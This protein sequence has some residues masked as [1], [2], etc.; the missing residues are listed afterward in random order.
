ML[1]GTGYIESWQ[2][3]QNI[4]SVKNESWP[5]HTGPGGP[6]PR[7][8]NEV[9]T[10]RAREAVRAEDLLYV[11]EPGR[12]WKGIDTQSYKRRALNNILI[13]SHAQFSKNRAMEMNARGKIHS[14]LVP[15]RAGVEP[16]RDAWILELSPDPDTQT[17]PAKRRAW[18]D[19]VSKWAVSGET[20]QGVLYERWA[21]LSGAYS[22]ADQARFCIHAEIGRVGW[23][24]DP[25]TGDPVAT[26]PIY[27]QK[28]GQIYDELG[29]L[30]KMLTA[31]GFPT[32]KRIRNIVTVQ[33]DEIAAPS[34]IPA[35][36]E[37]EAERIV[38]LPAARTAEVAE[39]TTAGGDAEIEKLSAIPEETARSI[40]IQ[41][42]DG[43]IETELA[44]LLIRTK[45][46]R[47]RMNARIVYLENAVA[48]VRVNNALR[49]VLDTVEADLCDANQEGDR[50]NN[51]LKLLREGLDTVRQGIA[52]FAT[53]FEM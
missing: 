45:A 32:L 9:L 48:T 8:L 22:S 44:D 13:E 11:H 20:A 17:S 43:T 1:N 4:G 52:E 16:S 38:R 21:Q 3:F 46:E 29:R 53:E 19:I 10:W 39:R 5:P 40:G 42:D 6:E 27:P 33:E 23:I 15:T 50:S 28:N 14:T 18:W 49:L 51:A 24:I 47:K 41:G 7:E 37:G 31:A 26:T 34:P 2:E 35:A 30:N 12:G 25:H 36:E